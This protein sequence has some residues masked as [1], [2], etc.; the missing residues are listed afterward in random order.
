MLDQETGLRAYLLTHQD[1]FLAP[2]TQATIALER[3]NE[4]LVASLDSAADLG[5]QMIRVRVA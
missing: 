5:R 4:E 1:R 2:Y 3:A